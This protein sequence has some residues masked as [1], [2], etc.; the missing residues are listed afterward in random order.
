MV[1]GR[2][3][4]RE[5]ERVR[6]GTCLLMSTH[7]PSFLPQ[8][9]E[10]SAQQGMFLWTD[11]ASPYN[12]SAY[13]CVDLPKQQLSAFY[14]ISGNVF[15][16]N[17]AFALQLVRRRESKRARERERERERKRR[18]GAGKKEREREREREREKRAREKREREERR[19]LLRSRRTPRTAKCG[20]TPSGL[21][22]TAPSPVPSL[23]HSCYLLALSS[24]VSLSLS[25]FFYAS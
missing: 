13:P 16:A 19:V 20:T 5:R 12:S 4:E 14:T 21:L 1:A 11:G 18:K 17:A 15:R 22:R 9:I 25:R 6:R 8:T 3:R 7:L 10:N 24:F 2:E 23:S